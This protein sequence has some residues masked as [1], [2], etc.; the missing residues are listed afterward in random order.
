MT[1]RPALYSTL[2]DPG[3]LFEAWRTV[4]ANR[5]APGIDWMTIREFESDLARNLESLAHRLR[6]QRYYPMPLRSTAIPKRRGGLRTLGICTVED[7]IVQRAVNDLLTPIYEPEFLDCSHGYRPH[8]SV[9]TA[10]QQ[11][12]AYRDGGDRY[13]VDADL[14]DFFPSIDHDL[15][16][17]LL[18]RR[19]RDQR[20]L[21]LIRM[22]LETGAV[23]SLGHRECA[24]A[25]AQALGERLTGFVS[26]SIDSAVMRLWQE[27][28]GYESGWS[29]SKS[30]TLAEETVQSNAETSEGAAESWRREIRQE[31][32]RRLGRDGAL[33]LLSYA[34]RAKVL[35]TPPGLLVVGMAALSLAAVPAARS[36]I[37]HRRR[38]SGARGLAQ[39]GPLAPLLSNIYLHEFDRVMTDSGH[40]LVRYADDW[41]ILCRDAASARTA[42]E[43]AERR[44]SE[45]RLRMHPEK[46]AIRPLDEG[47]DFLGCKMEGAE[48]GGFIVI[49][50]HQQ[51]DET[52]SW[53]PRTLKTYG[54]H[55][56]AALTRLGDRLTHWKNRRGDGSNQG[57]RKRGSDDDD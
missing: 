6:E 11:V 2:C 22:W 37:R 30:S 36:L 10:F 9:D 29:A 17:R 24:V 34:G 52:H 42:Y 41:V 8:R 1:R 47:L 23:L 21:G 53:F 33:L 16:L 12:R 48:A 13:V 25:W 14:A 55:A 49:A 4:R 56:G 57:Y 3:T 45:L 5:G 54:E 31:A 18:R 40:H 32:L 43:M 50:D 19:V 15:L 7:R 39:G 44:L 35:L 28:A 27:R 51:D 20:I 46:T 38:V 26:S